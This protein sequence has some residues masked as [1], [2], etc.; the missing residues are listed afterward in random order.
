MQDKVKKKTILIVTPA[1]SGGSWISIEKIL[2]KLDSARFRIEIIALGNSFHRVAHFIYHTIPYLR[3][4]KHGRITTI[5][6]L[7]AALWEFPLLVVAIFRLI[8]KRPNLTIYNG[9]SLGLLLSPL[10]KL[11]GLKYSVVM[12]HGFI[13]E[14]QST[15]V[16]IMRLLA[17]AISMVVV[18]SEGSRLN[19]I[20]FVPSNKILVNQHFAD[21]VFFDLPIHK[22]NSDDSRGFTA[23]VLYIGRLDSDKLCAALIDAIERRGER[24]DI[25]YVFCGVGQYEERIK[26]LM[27]KNYNVSYEGYVSDRE[28]LSQLY[29][30]ASVVW[31]YADETYLALPAIEAL[32]SGRPI[33]IPKYAA[34]KEKSAKKIQIDHSL[35]PPD[36]GWLVDPFSESEVDGLIT[37]IA[38]DGVPQTMMI[39]ARKLALHLYSQ[40]NLTTTVSQITNLAEGGLDK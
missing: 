30:S 7:I 19:I 12:Y 11:L 5:S 22:R 10:S 4:D 37:S 21:Q 1:L 20:S 24:N 34:L 17:Q 26:D 31:S 36:T 39:N 29:H 32:A 14:A 13:G 6:P 2:L 28:Q 18:N 33:I 25:K 23:S 9:F 3:Y 35:V 40:K 15:Y 16:W 38:R 8:L 27:Q